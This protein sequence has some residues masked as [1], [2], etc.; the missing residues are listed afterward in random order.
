M[1]DPALDVDHERWASRGRMG[2]RGMPSGCAGR[3]AGGSP[4]RLD[5][6]WRH[7][8]RRRTRC[9]PPS[10]D[11]GDERGDDG[12]RRQPEGSAYAGVEAPPSQRLGQPCAPSIEPGAAACPDG[13]IG[14]AVRA[15]D[16]R[17]PL[18]HVEVAGPSRPAWRRSRLTRPRYRLQPQQALRRLRGI[19]AARQGE[20]HGATLGTQPSPDG[21]SGPDGDDGPAPTDCADLLPR[22]RKRERGSAVRAARLISPRSSHRA[23]RRPTAPS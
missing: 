21:H 10:E 3:R 23:G 16:Y 12:Q 19:R 20:G 1:Q 5:A 15:T 6:R 8:N 17:D 22:G 18:P 14:P 2:G 13:T 11:H 4:R 7:G 9:R